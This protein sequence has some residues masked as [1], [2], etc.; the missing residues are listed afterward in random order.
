MSVSRKILIPHFIRFH[1]CIN[2]VHHNC[3]ICVTVRNCQH[4]SCSLSI[5]QIIQFYN[6][7]IL[8]SICCTM[9]SNKAFCMIPCPYNK[10]ISIYIVIVTNQAIHRPVK[11]CL[12]LRLNHIFRTII[13]CFT[14]TAAK[15]RHR[16]YNIHFIHLSCSL[17]IF[18]AESNFFVLLR[19][20][21]SIN[22]YI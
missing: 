16:N 7:D 20:I 2:V 15:T 17:T 12:S 14:E 19:L 9:L 18:P 1:I 4:T 5:S 8:N 21:T 22:F 6:F 10:H 3:L 11:Q 13:P